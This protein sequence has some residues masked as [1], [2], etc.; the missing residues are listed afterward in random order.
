MVPEQSVVNSHN[1]SV[2][3][4]T[5]EYERQ[6]DLVKFSRFKRLGKGHESIDSEATQGPKGTL[7]SKMKLKI[8]KVQMKR[9]CTLQ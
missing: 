4:Q 8:S 9:N 5:A 3:T 6:E 1:L 2:K 7:W